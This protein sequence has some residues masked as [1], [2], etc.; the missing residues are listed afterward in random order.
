MDKVSEL[1]IQLTQENR[2]IV[3]AKIDELLEQQGGTGGA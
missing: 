1:Y 3:D 2:R